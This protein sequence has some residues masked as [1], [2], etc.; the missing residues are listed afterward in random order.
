[1]NPE[2]IVLVGLVVSILLMIVGIPIALALGGV[3]I[4]CGLITLDAVFLMDMFA[5]RAFG[6]MSNYTLIAIP[7]FV[8]MGAILQRSG[9]TEKLFDVLFVMFGKL[10]GS[11]ALVT[12]I[13]GIVF[14]ACTGVAGA[15]VVTLGMLGIPAM[16]KRKYDHSLIAGCIC[17]GA[18]L[19]VIIPP[20]IVFILY[21][22]TAGV[23]ISALFAA[24]ILPG[25]LLGLLYLVY[26]YVRYHIL[27]PNLAP[28]ISIEE[29]GEYT[30]AVLIAMTIKSVLPPL[31]LIGAV[32]GAIFVGWAAPSE[33]AAL[34]A[35]GAILVS[36]AYKQFNVRTL[37]D[38]CYSTIKVSS[39]IMFIVLA[40]DMFA[41]VFLRAGANR[42]VR[43]LILGM[44]VS[45]L[46]TI[47]IMVLILYVCG[48]FMD[49]IG[50]IY[51]FIPIFSPIV[52]TLG[53]DPLWFG[54]V[55]CI[56][57]QLS[58]LTPPF[59]YNVFYL[60]SIAPKEITI[61]EMYKGVLPYIAVQLVF[62]ILIIAYPNI[63]LY[64]P[65]LI[66]GQ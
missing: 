62:L 54:V 41:G 38:S 56:I 47:I 3:A 35:I 32:L 20:S 14:G 64:V 60:K 25:L 11:L 40:A 53:Y 2:I 39:A 61:G 55:F 45:P 19:G 23:S 34:G 58:Y 36:L 28:A 10:R 18:G 21:G 48:M 57:L 52:A 49:W 33:A 17:A 9:I 24:G 27:Q 42:F 16:L 65:N 15:S 8:F 66:A 13:V 6:V 31:L 7:L 5:L 63:I 26:I 44:D 46:G 12:I 4:V 1:M 50:M 51:I 37:V 59:A 29:K 30:P 22:S 43:D